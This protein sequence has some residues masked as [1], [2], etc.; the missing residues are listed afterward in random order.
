MFG[1]KSVDVLPQIEKLNQII[2]DKKTPLDETRKSFSEM[3]LLVNHAKLLHTQAKKI[4][5]RNLETINFKVK[6]LSKDTDN[7]YSSSWLKFV[8]KP[9]S[10]AP[11]TDDFEFVDNSS[12]IKLTSLLDVK[13]NDFIRNE[14][15][16]VIALNIPGLKT[17][18]TSI[19]EIENLS[20]NYSPN[21]YSHSKKDF[22]HLGPLQTLES[23]LNRLRNHEILFKE[24]KNKIKTAIIYN[25]LLYILLDEK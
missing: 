8:N 20:H 23:D 1:I 12:N 9:Y 19:L 17:M 16:G 13:S 10:I 7:E 3:R 6:E 21:I 14:P 11:A 25:I 18:V 2:N 22:R 24:E 5:D 15:G 4:L